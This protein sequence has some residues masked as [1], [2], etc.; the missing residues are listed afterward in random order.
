MSK[1]FRVMASAVLPRADF[2]EI[3]QA[4]GGKQYSLFQVAARLRLIKASS[5]G[6]LR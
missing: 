5:S 4:Q 6:G 1:A 3:E 2:L